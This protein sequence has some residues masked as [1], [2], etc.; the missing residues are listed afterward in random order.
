VANRE[1][2]RWCF[3]PVGR[4]A[5]CPCG[6]SKYKKCCLLRGRLPGASSPSAGGTGELPDWI[7]NS[8]RKLHQFDKCA[9]N[10]GLPRLLGGLSDGRREPRIPTFDVV[11]SRFHTAVLGILSLNA[12]EGDLREAD[13]QRLIGGRPSQ[14]VEVFSGDVVANVLHTLDLEDARRADA[15][16]RGAAYPACR[17]HKAEPLPASRATLTQGEPHAYIAPT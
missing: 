3:L 7:I 17:P 2:G 10:V 14:E 4:N 6:G 5:P 12:L 11:N 1:V 16:Q 15:G 8:R 13:F 9:C